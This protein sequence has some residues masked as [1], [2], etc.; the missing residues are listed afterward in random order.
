MVALDVKI[1][2]ESSENTKK[3]KKILKKIIKKRKKPKIKK[4]ILTSL[5]FP[6]KVH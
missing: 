3:K 6:L 5:Q 2:A 1:I 4:N